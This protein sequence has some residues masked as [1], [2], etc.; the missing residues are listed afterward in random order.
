MK[1]I[2]T[3]EEMQVAINEMQPPIYLLTIK[4]KGV[5]YDWGDNR[6]VQSS[7]TVV[8]MG[9]TPSTELKGDTK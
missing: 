2:N 5:T 4:N 6:I 3:I 1:N 8:I 9:K 7:S